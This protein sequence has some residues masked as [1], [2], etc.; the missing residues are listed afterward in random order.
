MEGGPKEILEPWSIDWLKFR[1]A[2][3][4]Y[5]MEGGRGRTSILFPVNPTAIQAAMLFE[6]EAASFAVEG[7]KLR[8]DPCVQIA[9]GWRTI[10]GQPIQ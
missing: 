3:Q 1:L 10:A 4:K 8:S 9:R 2:A 7:D 6:Q 5:I